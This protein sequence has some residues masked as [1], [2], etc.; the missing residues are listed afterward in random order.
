MELSR[1]EQAQDL[2]RLGFILYPGCR[3]EAI[4]YAISIGISLDEI[5]C[6][7]SDADVIEAIH[8]SAMILGFLAELGDNVKCENCDAEVDLS[9]LMEC[10]NCGREFCHLCN[11][12]YHP[13]KQFCSRECAVRGK[14]DKEDKNGNSDE[15]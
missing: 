6:K 4:E 12:I 3:T 7:F 13:D 9:E 15:V 14:M 2:R 8:E 10:D 5:I 11:G 1:H